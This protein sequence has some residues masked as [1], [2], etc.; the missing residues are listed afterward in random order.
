VRP[1]LQRQIVNKIDTMIAKLFARRQIAMQELHA[2]LDT[3][4]RFQLEAQIRQIDEDVSALR[5]FKLEELDAEEDQKGL[6]VG[7]EHN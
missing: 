2:K 6:L 7:M 3:E 4:K 1:F 5:R